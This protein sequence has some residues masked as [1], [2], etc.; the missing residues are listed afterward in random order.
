MMNVDASSDCD[1]IHSEEFLTYT[2]E[3]L[4]KSVNC[5]RNQIVIE[6]GVQSKRTFIFFYT[7]VHQFWLK[8]STIWWNFT[9]L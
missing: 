7:A 4:D 3:L 5:F 2:I 1:T 6:D 9:Q 8:Y